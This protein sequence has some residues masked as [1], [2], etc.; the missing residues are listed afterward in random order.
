MKFCKQAEIKQFE[1]FILA[2]RTTYRCESKIGGQSV[3]GT[4]KF[5]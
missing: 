1:E 4:K 5:L 2:F 3:Y